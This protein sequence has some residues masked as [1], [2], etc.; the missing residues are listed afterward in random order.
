MLLFAALTLAPVLRADPGTNITLAALPSYVDRLFVPVVPRA[1]NT[2]DIAALRAESIVETPK[3]FDVRIVNGNVVVYSDGGDASGYA[4]VRAG[5][6]ELT[7]TLMNV[8]PYD[9]MQ[10]GSL[11]GYRV[12]EYNPAP[13]K[14]LEQ[15]ER[16]K[17]FIR[18][19]S[20]NANLWVSDH[21][22]LRDFQCK[23]DG[24]TKFIVLRT[25]ALLKLEI[26]QN[27]L[28]TTRGLQFD[29]VNR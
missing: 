11:E 14:G 13:L 9:R 23:L 1:A 27:E 20:A 5:G 28:A 4:K 25:D 17:G 26:L 7:L 21:Y 6:R 24:A 18:L 16:P 19:G 10:N 12:G 15:Y 29:R 22:R 8:V 2:V 3:N